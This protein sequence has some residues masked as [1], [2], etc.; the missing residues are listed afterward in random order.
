MV[1][2]EFLRLYAGVRAQTGRGLGGKQRAQAGGC[3]TG[4]AGAEVRPPA[5]HGGSSNAM[6]WSWMQPAHRTAS[7][8][9]PPTVQPPLNQG[10]DL[11]VQRSSSLGLFL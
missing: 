2:I 10:A 11:R 6:W 7:A 8:K 5:P 1:G 9:E 3:T 4:G